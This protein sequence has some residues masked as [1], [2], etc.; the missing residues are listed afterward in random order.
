MD[1]SHPMRLDCSWGCTCCLCPITLRYRIVVLTCSS[2][3]YYRYY[4]PWLVF[5]EWW[6]WCSLKV[7]DINDVLSP[8][9]E[10]SISVAQTS[11]SPVRSPSRIRS[12][13]DLRNF[14]FRNSVFGFHFLVS[15]FGSRFSVVKSDHENKLIFVLFCCSGLSNVFTEGSSHI[16]ESFWVHILL[17]RTRGRSESFRNQPRLE[18]L[19]PGPRTPNTLVPPPKLGI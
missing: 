2:K 1:S 9:I 8:T 11:L 19:V 7:V 5:F 4:L 17:R 15:N 3:Y 14:F 13:F 12:V 16:Q 6:Q 10:F 18:S